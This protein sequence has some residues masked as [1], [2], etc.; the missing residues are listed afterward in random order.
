MRGEFVAMLKIGDYPI[1]EADLDEH[2]GRRRRAADRLRGF[3]RL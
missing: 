1:K 3:C 2:A